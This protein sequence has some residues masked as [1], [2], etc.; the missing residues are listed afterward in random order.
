MCAALVGLR[1]TSCGCIEPGV[2]PKRHSLERRLSER[3]RHEDQW[4]QTA[5]ATMQQCAR[6][7]RGTQQFSFV[8]Q[9]RRCLPSPLESGGGVVSRRLASQLGNEQKASE[10][11]LNN[12]AAAVFSRV[13][14]GQ[15]AQARDSSG[16]VVVVVIGAANGSR[17][18]QAL[19]KSAEAQL[20]GESKS[21]GRKTS[22]P[23]DGFSLAHV[24]LNVA[25]EWRHR[26][27]L[28]FAS[29]QR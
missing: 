20:S 7:S 12:H 27:R 8:T 22:A 1:L 18:K 26:W 21:M 2:A 4:R 3:H 5:A 9:T 10:S 11:R 19:V 17:P 15:A 14:W 28:S 23:L 24:R 29:H 16:V 6:Q 13:R 25:A